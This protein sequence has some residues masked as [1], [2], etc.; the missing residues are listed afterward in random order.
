MSRS[1]SRLSAATTP[2]S[3]IGFVPRYAAS[4]A[5]SCCTS[6][7]VPALMMRPKSR[8]WITSQTS[9]TSCTSCSTSTTA[10][11][12]LA[13]SRNKR[14]NSWVSCSSWP[15]RGLVEQHDLGHGGERSAQ[16]DDR[17]RPVDSVS[18]RAS[19][20]SVR[21]DPLEDAVDERSAVVPSGAA[22]VG[23]DQHVFAHRKLVEELE[24]LERRRE[25]E[26]G[27][28]RR[29]KFRDVAP[30]DVHVT[31]TGREQAGDHVEQRR[32]ARAVRSDQSGHQPALGGQAN[33]VEGDVSAEADRDRAYF[34]GRR[35]VVGGRIRREHAAG[36][37]QSTRAGDPTRRRRPDPTAR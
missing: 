24:T 30:F 29:P 17:A 31:S 28:P 35:A 5:S 12:S 6:W 27:T 14:P 22:D 8:T 26:P 34:E 15:D 18:T 19:A 1:S 33:A 36:P 21:T 3:V 32:L 25:A 4:T 2:T 11:P 23:G 20:T 37:P 10:R 16:F 13:S 7:G 9:I